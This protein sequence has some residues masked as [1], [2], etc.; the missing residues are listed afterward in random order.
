MEFRSANRR[1]AALCVLLV[2]ALV[3]IAMAQDAPKWVGAFYVKGKVGLKW[4]PVEGAS[5]Y[6][7]YRKAADEE[8]TKIA[9]EEK[10]HLFDTN[11]KPG[12]VYTYKIAAVMPDGSERFSSE[13]SVTIPGS[14]ATGA[15]APPQWVGI[16]LDRNTLFLNWDRVPGAIAYNVYRSETPGGPYEVVGNVTVSKFADREGLE[17]GKTYYYVLTALNEEFEETEYS[18][19]R[20]HKFGLSAEEIAA[21]EAASQIQLDSIKLTYLFQITSAGSQGDMN[22]PA[23]V[24]VNSKGN[25]YVTD[26]LN[27]RVHCFDNS[28]TYLFS[29]GE[30]TNPAMK[31][32]PP[33][34]TFSYPFS[35]FID[36]QDNVY[37]TDV[38]NHDIQV[39]TAEGKFL[40][41]IRVP[42]TEDQEPFRPNGIWVLDDGTIL[43]TDAG[44]H[45]FLK[46]SPDGKVLMAV[47]SRGT[48]EGQFNFPDGIVVTDDSVICVV[49][50]LNCRVQEFDMNGKFIRWFGGRGQNVGTF[51][52]P[53]D[54]IIG[55]KGWLWI[56]DAL[57]NAVQ[58]FT[59]EG[60]VKLAI[61][62]FEDE[63]VF[64]ATPRGM[65]IKD[66]RF[67]VVNR[68]PHQ[69]LV[70]QIG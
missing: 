34:G 24:F 23:D 45:R 29:F 28:G 9:S 66:G 62:H 6:N 67:Y 47:G 25:I 41:R 18:E 69:V 11:V 53:K 49:D 56:S 52:R 64:L 42:T 54:M 7:V 35:L 68:L 57:A 16:R 13:K 33:E 27:G 37:V 65:Y 19:E 40:R 21:A 14:A 58:A 31:D 30:P 10:T 5:S 26:A 15:F 51:G 32:D 59:V 8:Y 39:F 4:Q 46:L 2:V 3:A 44:N 17:R 12:V 55:P 43:C 1:S 48:G 36:R 60:Q 63:S 22:Q 61:N 20:S 38:I 70:F 50:V